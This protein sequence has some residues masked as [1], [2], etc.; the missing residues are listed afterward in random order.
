MR[1]LPVG[2]DHAGRLAAG[3]ATPASADSALDL[4]PTDDRDHDG[5]WDTV[6][7]QVTDTPDVEAVIFGAGDLSASQRARVDGNGLATPI[8]R[9]RFA[10]VSTI[11][12]RP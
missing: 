4:P 8:H 11:M 2:P 1:L 9:L 6:L 12:L 7:V 3:D 5:T 10:P